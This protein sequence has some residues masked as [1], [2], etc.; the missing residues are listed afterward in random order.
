MTIAIACDRR[1]STWSATNRQ[2]AIGCV[3]GVRFFLDI[4]A[5]D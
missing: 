2:P 5:L 4:F 1:C 3:N